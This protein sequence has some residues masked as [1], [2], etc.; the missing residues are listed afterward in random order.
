M[1]Q[2]VS[3]C[4]NTIRLEGMLE[5]NSPDK[6]VVITHPHPLYGGNMDNPVVVETA[7]AYAQK[8]Y[9]TLRFNFRGTGK[10]TGMY[11]NGAGEQADVR[12]ALEYLKELG[13]VNLCLAGYSFGAWVNAHLVSSHFSV[14]DHVMISPPAGFMSFS[15]VAHLPATGLIITGELDEIAPALKI[16]DLI[17]KWHIRP[18]F[19]VVKACDHFYSQNLE[20]LKALLLEYLS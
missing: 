9:T 17:E 6:A 11:D 16:A 13:V 8:E 14:D 5:K 15:N 2:L 19:E 12:S 18:R 7:K 3:I 20:Q 1:E 10:S 4:N